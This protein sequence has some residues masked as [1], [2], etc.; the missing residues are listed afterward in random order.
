MK[1]ITAIVML[2]VIVIVSMGLFV[3][4]NKNANLGSDFIVPE[5]GYDGSAVTIKFSHTMGQKLRKILDN[6]I[7]EFNKIYPNITVVHEQVGGYDEVLSDNNTKLAGGSENAPNLSYCYS[8]HV[9]VYNLSKSVIKLDSLANSSTINFDGTQ[10]GFTQAQK[11]DFIERFY[12]EGKQFG[13]GAMYQLPLSRSTE[14]LYYN[15]DF[16]DK[17]NNTKEESAPA[18]AVPT[19]WW[20]TE[21]CPADCNSSMEKVCELIKAKD[22]TATPLGY[23]SEA[24]WFITM[25]AQLGSGYTTLEGNDNFIFVNNQNKEF[26]KKLREWRQKGYVTTKSINNNSYT[27]DLFKVGEVEGT[28]KSYMCVGSSGGASYQQPDKVNGEYPFEI[29]IARLPQIDVAN[30]KTISQGPSLCIFNKKNPQEV[31]ATWLFAKFLTTNRL[32][33][34]EFAMESGYIPVIKSVDELPIYNDWLGKADGKDF[35]TAYGAKACIENQD[36]CFTSPAFNGSSSARE[37]VG[38]LL[39]QCM[40]AKTNDVNA[41]IDMAF[42]DAYDKCIYDQQ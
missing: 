4:C 27:S 10:V 40:S 36:A 8:D 32:F 2:V 29:G 37:Q 7:V 16:F 1:K 42:N 15:K 26:V 19:H 33:Q 41:L 11:E 28:L 39:A 35:I 3:A 21:A 34:A 6:Y 18:L 12:D 31:M 5:G 30:P 13:D 23:D 20:C 24:N 17:Y 22:A 25:A 9:A 14:V 38:L